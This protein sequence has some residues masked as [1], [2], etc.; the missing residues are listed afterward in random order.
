MS[1]CKYSIFV[2][3]IIE[4]ERR[5]KLEH[6]KLYS[7]EDNRFENSLKEFVKTFSFDTEPVDTETTRHERLLL[8]SPTKL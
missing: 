3:Q 1:G 5:I 4:S 2:C 6:R 7:A 8:T